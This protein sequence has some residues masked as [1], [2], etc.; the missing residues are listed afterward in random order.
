MTAAAI[1]GPY[2]DVEIPDQSL[3]AFVLADA[4]QHADKPALIDGPSGRTL[5]YGRLAA[6]VERVAAGLAERGLGKGDV[7][8]IYSP[9]LPEYA[10]AFYGVAAAGGIAT[11]INPLYTVDELAVQLQDTGARYLLTVPR[12]WT[13][14]ARQ[15]P[16]PAC[17][18]CSCSARAAAPRRSR[19]CYGRRPPRPGWRSTRPPTWPPCPT[20]VAR[21]GCPRGSC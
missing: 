12:S 2:P 11:T 7:L 15:P 8:A 18:R 10:L 3:P 20:P 14:L 6:G 16:A 17:G 13:R 19:P 21:P 9:N 1:Q 4:L 5:T